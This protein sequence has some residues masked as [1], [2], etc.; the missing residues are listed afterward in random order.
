MFVLRVF[1]SWQESS[2]K[3]LYKSCSLH[4][5][6][7]GSLRLT[8]TWKWKSNLRWKSNLLLLLTFQIKQIH[9]ISENFQFHYKK[10]EEIIAS[11]PFFLENITQGIHLKL[12][13]NFS[14]F[15]L[16]QLIK[17]LY[18]CRIRYLGFKFCLHPKI[19]WCLRLDV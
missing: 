10:G 14:W 8:T 18:Y 4:D 16:I 6:E 9:H 19:N 7:F 2:V 1:S 3:V 15:Q 13:N 5:L 12:Y 17:F 11:P